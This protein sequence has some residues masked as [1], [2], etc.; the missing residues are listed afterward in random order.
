MT[1]SRKTLIAA[2][3]AGAKDLAIDEDARRD[4]MERITGHRS[5]AK[6]T[7]GQLG[8]IL[9]EYRKL[10]RRPAGR[11]GFKPAANPL[12]RKVHALWGELK[13]RGAVTGGRPALR[14][15]CGRQLQPDETVLLDPDLLRNDQLNRLIEAL[16]G[17]VARV[18]KEQGHD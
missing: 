18:E 11:Q 5:A 10:G 6:C 13:K 2:V 12:A 14:K 9:D 8:A 3:H 17:W 1:T 16:K 7:D 4:L 15:W